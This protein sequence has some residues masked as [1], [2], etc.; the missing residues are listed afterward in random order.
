M[1]VDGL[2]A[3]RVHEVYTA[4]VNGKREPPKPAIASARQRKGSNENDTKQPAQAPCGYP[5]ATPVAE[6]VPPPCGR[7]VAAGAL[8]PEGL[9]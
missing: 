9:R 8:K 7:C 4:G 1:W 5:V 6:V 2:S 3:C